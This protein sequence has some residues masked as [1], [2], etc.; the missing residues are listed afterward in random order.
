MGIMADE[1]VS[2]GDTWLSISMLLFV[3][4][5][6]V[7]HGVLTPSMRKYNEALEASIGAAPDG[8]PSGPTPEMEAAGKR[9]AMAGA[10][11]NITVVVILMLMVWKPGLV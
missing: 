11:L 3:A 8:I 4:A 10:Y 2:L 9:T 6:G 7:S 1:P 5:V